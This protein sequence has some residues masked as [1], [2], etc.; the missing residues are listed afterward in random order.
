MVHGVRL[1]DGRAEWYRNR[2]VRTRQLAGASFVGPDGFDLTAVP[3]NTSVIRHASRI[4]ALVEVGLPYEL[5]PELTTIGPCD[6]GGEAH[7]RHDRASQARPA[8]R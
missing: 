4:L 2:W 5:T 1:R 3:A 8:H 7:D 6:F